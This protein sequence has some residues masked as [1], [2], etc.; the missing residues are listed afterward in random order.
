MKAIGSVIIMIMIL[1][2]YSIAIFAAVAAY[3]QPY[4]TKIVVFTLIIIA[5][6]TPAT[7]LTC[8]LLILSALERHQQTQTRNIKALAAILKERRQ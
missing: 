4:T 5:A 8:T 6:G 2:L 1:A 7:I 3:D